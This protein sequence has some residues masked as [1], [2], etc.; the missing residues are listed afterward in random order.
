[1]DLYTRHVGENEFSDTY[2][3]YNH[4]MHLTCSLNVLWNGIPT[5]AFHPTQGNSS[6]RPAIA[7]CLCSIHGAT[8]APLEKESRLG[9]WK[10]VQVSR[11]GP[12]I[13]HLMFA[14]DVV[15]FVEG[16]LEQ[17]QIIRGCLNRF[18]AASG[19]KINPQ[20]EYLLFAEYE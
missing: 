1:M 15:L 2:D 7:L 16:T 11:G 4:E 8:I 3:L 17:A 14:D 18:C 12:K 5:K 19:Q 20:V 9:H 13:S 10:P 6:G